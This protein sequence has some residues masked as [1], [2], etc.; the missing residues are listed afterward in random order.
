MAKGSKLRVAISHMHSHADYWKGPTTMTLRQRKAF[1]VMAVLLAL[2]FAQVYVQTSF[3]GAGGTGTPVPLPQQFVARLA[4]RG[5]QP[6]TVNGASASSGAT[7]LTGATIET[8]DQVGAT[9]DLGSLG[10]LDL[11]PGTKIQLDFDSNGHVKV[12]LISGCAILKTKKNTEGEIDTTQGTAG[13]TDKKNGGALDVCFPP[14]ASA[15]TV[16]AGA[17]AAA[18]AGASGGAGAVGAG[19]STAAKVLIVAGIG[20]GVAVV[21]VA[22]HGSNPSP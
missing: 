14:G 18:G 20:G 6:I 5:N 3:A 8:P 22:T 10:T 1:K 15:P 19:L 9:I 7:I 17:A 4:T 12:K 13:T 21:I 16:N 2:S 11:A